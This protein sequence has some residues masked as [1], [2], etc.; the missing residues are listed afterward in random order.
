MLIPSIV[1]GGAKGRVVAD[2]CA[3]RFHEG[4]D[5]KLARHH[6]DRAQ[7]AGDDVACRGV[8]G[9]AMIADGSYDRRLDRLRGDAP[10]RPCLGRLACET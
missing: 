9:V 10:Y 3:L 1:T 7:V 8:F 2:R 5:L 4:L 6:G